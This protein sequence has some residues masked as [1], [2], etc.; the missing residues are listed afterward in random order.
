MWFQFE[1]ALE[2]FLLCPAKLAL[3]AC[4]QAPNRLAAVQRPFCR[5][6]SRDFFRYDYLFSGKSD[7]LELINIGT[8]EKP[9][10]AFLV[11]QQMLYRIQGNYSERRPALVFLINQFR[12]GKLELLNPLE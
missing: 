10:P 11:G 5:R 4:V 7:A 8:E 12:D 2:S 3:R 6:L 9:S 1:E